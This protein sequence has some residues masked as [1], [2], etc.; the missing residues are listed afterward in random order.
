MCRRICP[1][2]KVLS[3]DG[4]KVAVTVQSCTMA[5]AD[6]QAQH[7]A[8]SC[9]GSECSQEQTS[10]SAEWSA[11]RPVGW[12]VS[13]VFAPSLKTWRK[14]EK[15]LRELPGSLRWHWNFT[16]SGFDW[17]F[18]IHVFQ[19]VEGVFQQG[20]LSYSVKQ[21][22][23]NWGGKGFAAETWLDLRAKSQKGMSISNFGWGI[24]GSLGP[25]L[26]FYKAIFSAS[27]SC[28]C[29]FQDSCSAECKPSAYKLEFFLKLPWNWLNKLRRLHK[30]KHF[31]WGVGLG[32]PI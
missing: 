10:R 18:L 6:R 12:F 27:Q 11:W 21:C 20:P 3:H 7:L 1:W 8:I 28:W 14:G 4:H 16:V 24:T 29:S 19:W 31:N 30:Y 26:D 32:L 25:A 23:P 22:W 9:L 2:R 17:D 5:I 13:T 15:Y